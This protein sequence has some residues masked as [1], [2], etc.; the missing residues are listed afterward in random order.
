MLELEP[1]RFKVIRQVRPKLAQWIGTTAALHALMGP[2]EKPIK[3]GAKVVGQGRSVA[4]QMAE[5]AIPRA[6]FAKIMQR[7]FALLLP[8]TATAT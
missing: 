2:R 6:L 5:V 8:P 3:F 7:I 1:V 4:M